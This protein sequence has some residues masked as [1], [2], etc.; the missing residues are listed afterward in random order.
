M[1]TGVSTEL[2]AFA[3]ALPAR[4]ALVGRDLGP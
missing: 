4:G 2:E 3:D 1:A